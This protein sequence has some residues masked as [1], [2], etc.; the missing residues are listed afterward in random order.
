LIWSL[1]SSLVEAVSKMGQ[2]YFFFCFPM[3]GNRFL[4][5]ALT[6]FCSAG[7]PFCATRANALRA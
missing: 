7:V 3:L 6:F 5:A 2:V 4:T 1:A